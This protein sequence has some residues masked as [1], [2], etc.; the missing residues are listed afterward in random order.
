MTSPT[1]DS[2]QLILI[3]IFNVYDSSLHLPFTHP[4]WLLDRLTTSINVFGDLTVAAFIGNKVNKN[5][6]KCIEND[7]CIGIVPGEKRSSDSD[8]DETI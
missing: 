6:D 4:S 1:Q 7:V 8:A 2:R 3:L 5:L